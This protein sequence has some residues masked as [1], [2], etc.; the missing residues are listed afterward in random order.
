MRNIE[1]SHTLLFGP[2]SWV[3]ISYFDEDQT[4]YQGEPDSEA[5]YP[6]STLDQNLD[7]VMERHFLNLELFGS[8]H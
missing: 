5:G 1:Q 4:Q 6:G 8:S 7:P 2:G 3:P